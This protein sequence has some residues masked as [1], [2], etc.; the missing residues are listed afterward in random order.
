MKKFIV[1]NTSTVFEK[2]MKKKKKNH[3]PFSLPA[4]QPLGEVPKRGRWRIS[5]ITYQAG[6]FNWQSYCNHKG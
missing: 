5:R 1:G 6:C 4:M 3:P 2:L